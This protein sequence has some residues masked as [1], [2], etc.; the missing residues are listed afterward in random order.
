MEDSH[1]SVQVAPMTGG[2]GSHCVLSMFRTSSCSDREIQG[3]ARDNARAPSSGYSDPLPSRVRQRS[4]V[5]IDTYS[6]YGS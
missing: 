6:V 4:A 1:A 5:T 3:R 2:Q